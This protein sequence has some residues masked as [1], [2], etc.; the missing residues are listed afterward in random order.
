VGDRSCPVCSCRVSV[1]HRRLRRSRR[2]RPRIDEREL[3]LARIVV[4]LYR[5][6]VA[7]RQHAG[8]SRAWQHAQDTESPRRCWTLP[9]VARVQVAGSDRILRDPQGVS[10][11]SALHCDV[12]LIA[13]CSASRGYSGLL[14]GRVGGNLSAAATS[15]W[16]PTETHIVVHSGLRVESDSRFAVADKPALLAG[17]RR[18][19]WCIQPIGY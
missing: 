12:K 8:P 9:A 6:S 3:R 4:W 17:N 18:R 14:F 10:A 1:W 11:R 2:V 16:S 15:W 13:A 19:R 7:V 5:V